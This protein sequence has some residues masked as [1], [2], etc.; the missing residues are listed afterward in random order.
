MPGVR[1]LH[2][3]AA[4]LPRGNVRA[5]VEGVSQDPFPAPPEPTPAAAIEAIDEELKFFDDDL[6]RFQV[7]I[8][9]GRGLPEFPAGWHRDELLVQGCQA[10][11]WLQPA[12]RDGR[13]WLAGD[14]DAPIVKGLVAIMLRVYG[15]R[16][17]AEVAA[18]DP[19][20]LKELGL[21][22][23]LSTNRGNGIAAMAR[24]IRLLAAAASQAA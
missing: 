16:T 17:P 2:P 7:I 14:S 24:Q 1:Q 22:G 18:A 11:V 19:A 13:L 23:S 8:D 20:F 15:G 3:T 6:D 10:R 4:A 5:Y 12:W 21:L 9:W